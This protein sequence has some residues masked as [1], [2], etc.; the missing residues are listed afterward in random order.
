MTQFTLHGFWESGNAYKVALM[1]ELNG[2]D[3]QCRRV[4]F[5]TGETRRAP[6]RALNVMG[7]VP[8]LI[9]HRDDGDVTLTQSGACLT[10]LARHFGTY[11][12][13][14]EAEDY[15]VLRWLLFDSQKVSGYAGPLRFL[16]HLKKTGETPE[17]GF[18]H[19]R[20]LAALAVLDAALDGR[21]WLV[22]ERATIADLACQ[23]YLHWPEQIGV[24]YDDTP[25]VAAWLERIRT[26]PGYRRSEDLMPSGREPDTATA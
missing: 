1:L 15:D 14:T 26:L 13:T 23:G 16:R 22:G 18:L 11:G 21:D 5:F 8:V 3:W 6:F 19:G 2:A 17:V 4:A 25:H 20:F 7:E 12:P 10:Y 24:T 9:H